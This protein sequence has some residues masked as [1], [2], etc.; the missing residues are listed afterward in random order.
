[1]SMAK[2]TLKG[3]EVNT[4]SEIVKAGESAP[5][6][7]LVDSDLNDVNLASYEGKKQNFKY[8]AKLR[9]T[10]VSKINTNI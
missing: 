8:C 9:H 1:M 3:N 4:N 5:D 10:G 2:I 7:V 6:F